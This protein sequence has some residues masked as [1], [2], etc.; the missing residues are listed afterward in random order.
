MSTK[1]THF[2]TDFKHE[3]KKLENN[4][5]TYSLQYTNIDIGKKDR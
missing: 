2:Y 5:T 4:E 3:W 1:S